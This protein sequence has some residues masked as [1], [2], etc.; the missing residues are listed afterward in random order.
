MAD[1]LDNRLIRQIGPNLVYR[2]DDGTIRQIGPDLVYRN[3][4]GTIRQI[5][6][7]LVYRK[8]AASWVVTSSDGEAD[9]AVIYTP[10]PPGQHQP[11]DRQAAPLPA[12]RLAAIGVRF[13]LLKARTPRR[14]APRTFCQRR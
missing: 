1:E 12:F 3:D 9:Q 11:L 10:V 2:N 6:P 7:D 14:G 8:L 4:D 13:Q 5:G